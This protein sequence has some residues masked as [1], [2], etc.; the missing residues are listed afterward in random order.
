[1][2]ERLIHLWTMSIISRHDRS[3]EEATREFGRRKPA[4]VK[5]AYSPGKSSRVTL[6]AGAALV[7]LIT[8]YLLLT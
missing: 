4:A 3:A 2:V 1:M 6:V 8:A 7:A 5:P